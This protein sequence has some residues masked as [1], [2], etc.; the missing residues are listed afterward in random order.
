MQKRR[1]S[2]IKPSDEWNFNTKLETACRSLVKSLGERVPGG[3]FGSDYLRAEYL[4]KFNG[5][6]SAS[7]SE[8]R[9]AAIR[10]WRTSN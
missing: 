5:K 10:K 9:E 6:G 3:T 4:S 8:R 1:K 7:A 2:R